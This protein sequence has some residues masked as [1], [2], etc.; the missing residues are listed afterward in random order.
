[1]S[2]FSGLSYLEVM[3]LCIFLSFERL[4]YRVSGSKKEIGIK[5]DEDQLKILDELPNSAVEMQVKDK[6]GNFL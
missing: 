2:C 3:K 1:M 5:L 6:V 4:R